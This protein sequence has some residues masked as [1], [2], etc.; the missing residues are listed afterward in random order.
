MTPIGNWLSRSGQLVEPVRV[1]ERRDRAL[2]QEAR[3]DGVGE[4]RELHA[5]GP[6]HRGSERLEEPPDVLVPARQPEPRG[7]ADAPGIAHHQRQLEAARDQHAPGGRVTGAGE[8]PG[9]GERPDHRHVEQDRRRGRRREAL[10][11]VEDAAVERDHRHQQQIRKGDPREFHGER[12]PARVLGETRR[13][14]RNHPR[15]ERERDDQQHHLARDQKCEDAVREQAH[16]VGA[17]LLA[18]ARIGRHEGGIEGALGEDGPEMVGQSQRDEKR[19]GNR[20]G[21]EHGGEHDVAN[22]AGEARDEGQAADGQDAL[23][24]GDS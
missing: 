12:K 8:Q 19:V 20:A 24:H 5:R 10:A 16:H 14:Q 9:A 18:D 3:D 22:K 21:A 15:H 4:Q 17:L 1:V 2:R 23:D 6:D 7:R 13:Q 11:G